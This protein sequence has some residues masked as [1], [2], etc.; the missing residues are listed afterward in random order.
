MKTF[1]CYT[2]GQ[3]LFFDNVSCVKC[4]ATLGYLPDAGTLEAI[5][6]I[7][8]K[9]WQT[10]APHLKGRLYR[11]CENYQIAQ[12]CNWLVPLDEK[13]NFCLSCRLNQTIPNN[14]LVWRTLEH[15]KRQLIYSILT[16]GLPLSNKKEQPLRG[17][18][19]AF[20]E[21]TA[22]NP[23][24]T[25]HQSGLI[26][27]NIAEVDDVKREWMRQQLHEPY[28]TLLGHFRHEIGHYYWWG[29]VSYTQWLTPFRQLFGDERKLPYHDALKEHYQESGQARWQQEFISHYAS[30]HPLEDWAETWAHYLH[31]IDTLEMAQSFDLTINIPPSNHHPLPNLTVMRQQPF[32]Q[33]LL[34]W[35]PLTFALNSLNRTMGLQD[36]YPFILP[37]KV[38]AKLSFIH[39]VVQHPVVPPLLLDAN[40]A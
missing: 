32:E 2:C 12:V 38:I 26:T 14:Q 4:G 33:T 11:L 39:Q 17:L 24:L 40:R 1:K 23:V 8:P 30:V 36:M 15:A 25:G 35:L 37:P 16:L 31:I 5:K 20:L 9:Q 3:L 22:N 13:Q 7:K 6:E 28:R 19:F 27:I 21:S 29:L 10:L 18:A 34:S